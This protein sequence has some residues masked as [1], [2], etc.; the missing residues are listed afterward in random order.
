[1]PCVETL[2]EYHSG[3]REA[4]F[5]R[6]ICTALAA[7]GAGLTLICRRLLENPVTK[8]AMQLLSPVL[9]TGSVLLTRNPGLFFSTSSADGRGM[10]AG[11][12]GTGLEGREKAA[13]ADRRPAARK[14]L[15]ENMRKKG[16]ENF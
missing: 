11:S 4:S 6:M 13:D 10:M 14:R 3:D 7:E 12:P 1:M 16:M 9:E 15:L 2:M 5:F 8:E